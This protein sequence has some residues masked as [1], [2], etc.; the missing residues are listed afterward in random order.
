MM[1]ISSLR[2]TLFSRTQNTLYLSH[3]SFARNVQ[4]PPPPSTDSE[5]KLPKRMKATEFSVF[6]PSQSKY[7]L[8]REAEIK[9]KVKERKDAPDYLKNE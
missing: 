2:R 9:A 7:G 1:L 3:F 6:D 5:P 4:K 8:T